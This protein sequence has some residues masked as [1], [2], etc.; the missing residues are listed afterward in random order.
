MLSWNNTLPVVP[1]AISATCLVYDVT[2]IPPDPVENL[3]I[4]FQQVI[5]EIDDTTSSSVNQQ[6]GSR[7]NR[8]VITLQYTWSAPDFQGEGITGY[9]SRLSLEPAPE[10]GMPSTGILRQI[11]RNAMQ[12]ELTA[13]FEESDTNVTLYFQVRITWFCLV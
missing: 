12:D 3:A 4:T 2:P 11:G 9:Q 10:N 5:P 8:L 6:H 1:P 13:I 7:I